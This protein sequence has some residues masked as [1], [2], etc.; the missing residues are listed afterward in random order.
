MVLILPQL[1][2]ILW[3]TTEGR[4]CQRYDF[5]REGMVKDQGVFMFMVVVAG[6]RLFCAPAQIQ[7]LCS[8]PA[9]ATRP[10]QTPMP[11]GLPRTSHAHSK[12]Q[13]EPTPL[14]PW[15]VMAPPTPFS[16]IGLPTPPAR[17][18]SARR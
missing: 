4:T 16:T 11:S 18:R 1:L 9:F 7:N 14:M 10:R 15:R 13:F 5:S 12:P 2:A 6:K 8:S 3:K 17:P